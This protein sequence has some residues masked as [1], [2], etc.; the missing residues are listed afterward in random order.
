M[1][2]GIPWQVAGAGAEK[3]SL[4]RGSRSAG[5]GQDPLGDDGGWR[6]ASAGPPRA[7]GHAD[8]RD[9]PTAEPPF[10]PVAPGTQ[11]GWPEQLLLTAREPVTKSP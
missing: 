6:P 10:R 9:A 1:K 7:A 8:H 2:S 11:V 4:G 3:A 5:R